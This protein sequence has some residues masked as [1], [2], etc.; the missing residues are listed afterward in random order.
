MLHVLASLNKPRRRRGLHTV[1][2]PSS[3]LR[4]DAGAIGSN[5]R[6]MAD[7]SLTYISRKSRLSDL[8][9]NACFVASQGFGLPFAHPAQ[10]PFIGREHGLD[11]RHH[12]GGE[13]VFGPWD[14]AGQCSSPRWSGGSAHDEAQAPGRQRFA[15]V[16]GRDILELE[17]AEYLAHQAL[18]GGPALFQR[19]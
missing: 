11:A 9:Q 5:P 17:A 10:E 8:R 14:S 3:S 16:H 18:A 1:L 7:D 13:G 4:L 12:E 15:L 19:Q 2:A 6:Q